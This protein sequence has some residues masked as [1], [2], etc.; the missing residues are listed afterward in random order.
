MPIIQ[1]GE[2]LIDDET[3]EV[4]NA[5]FQTP[6]Q[7]ET[8]DHVEWLHEKLFNL[9]AE[10]AMLKAKRARYIENID[11]MMYET[12]SKRDWLERRYFMDAE[13]VVRENCPKNAKS[14]KTPFGR[15]GFQKIGGNLKIAGGAEDAAVEWCKLNAPDAVKTVESVLVSKL[16][17][18]KEKM[19][20][21]VKKGEKTLHIP[22][23]QRIF[24]VEEE[25][26]KFYI[27]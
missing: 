19:E 11:K 18:N 16:D 5:A 26:D 14:V 12:Q 13:A 1:S 10:E 9:N 4:V 6:F 8:M 2:F 17:V 25:T 3:G 21:T 15:A 23:D 24:F 20:L 7:I 27:K 22:L